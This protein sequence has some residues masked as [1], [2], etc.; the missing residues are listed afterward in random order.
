MTPPGIYTEILSAEASYLLLGGLGGI[1]RA[2]ASLLVEMGAKNL[3]LLSRNGPSNK[4]RKD[5]LRRLRTSGVDVKVLT[6]DVSEA[7]HLE[8]ALASSSIS[9]VRPRLFL[10]VSLL[11][12]A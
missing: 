6:C 1:G 7:S 4:N 3:L 12:W 8:A 10:S 2:I 11:S 9:S 5:L